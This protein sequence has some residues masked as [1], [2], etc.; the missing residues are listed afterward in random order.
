MGLLFR[1]ILAAALLA[2]TPAFA[3]ADDIRFTA[4]LSPDEQSIPT[5]SDAVGFAEVILE[6]ETLK[7][8]WKVTYKDL[9]SAPTKA[10]LFG[11]ENP[12]AN[13]GMF[14]DFGKN[15]KSPIEGSVVLTDGQFQYLITGRVYVNVLSA[16]WPEGELRGQLRRQR[17]TG[18]PTN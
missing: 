7:I 18:T 6:R 10:G 16:K 14:V 1:T 4:S 3:G 5:H 12:G 2:G 9:S 11:P 13:A 15:L 17:K 8:T